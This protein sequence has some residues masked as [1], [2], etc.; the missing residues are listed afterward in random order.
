MDECEFVI[1]KPDN[2]VLERFFYSQKKK[3]HSINVLFLVLLDKKVIFQSQANSGKCD[4]QG[5]FYK[6]DLRYRFESI[7]V[8]C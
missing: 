1:V 6:T 2:S 8:H 5:V 7:D 3:Q 4:D